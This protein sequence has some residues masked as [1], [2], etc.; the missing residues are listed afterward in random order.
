ME[1]LFENNFASPEVELDKFYSSSFLVNGDPNFENIFPSTNSGNNTDDPKKTLATQLENNNKLFQD[2]VTNLQGTYNDPSYGNRMY[3]FNP[4]FKG[5]NMDRYD[6]TDLGFDPFRDNE[7]FYND[8]TS[9]LY[10][11]GRAFDGFFRLTGSAFVDTATS[12]GRMVQGDFDISK[13]AALDSERIMAETMSTKSGFLPGV[14]NFMVNTGFTAGVLAELWAEE[15]L[16]A[17]GSALLAAPSGGTSLGAGGILAA[18]RAGMAG[19]KIV[20][21]AK[22]MGN[23][24]KAL[25]HLDDVNAARQYFNSFGKGTLQFFNP[26]QKS[27]ALLASGELKGLNQMAAASKGFGAFFGDI[28]DIF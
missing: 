13:E 14:A 20:S 16:I 21:M 11:F 28:R 15:M 24:A 6:D 22:N 3:G 4:S 10:D 2:K 25:T 9:M 23:L 7:K 17:A 18:A 1:N 12:L 27:T 19:S 8:N 5:L 26:L